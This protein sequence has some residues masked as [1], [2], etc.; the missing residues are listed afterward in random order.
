M[1]SAQMAPMWFKSLNERK[2][3]EFPTYLSSMIH[4]FSVVPLAW[5]YIYLDYQTEVHKPI[6]F[7]NFLCFV[8]PLCSG[9][10][11]ADTLFY[12]IPLTF[13]G[14]FEYVLHHGLALWL[15]YLFLYGPGCFTRFYPHLII[16]DTTNI[17]F[18]SA[19]LLRLAGFRDSAVVSALELMFSLF[20]VLI[21]AVNLTLVF[22]VILL[23]PQSEVFG[24]GRFVLPMISLLQFYWLGK[25][26]QSLIAKFSPSIKTKKL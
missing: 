3:A 23:N 10:V 16:C 22:G 15:I 17:L 18:N 19:W 1:I 26:A 14:N 6:D 24:V 13:R 8:A 11:V 20:F 12:A 5:Y 2:K 25:I 7:A 9:F 21:R 4:H